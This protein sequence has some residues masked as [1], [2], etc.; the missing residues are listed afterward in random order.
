VSIKQA[1]DPAPAATFNT[2]D[3][4][5][6]PFQAQK[7]V[8]L[9][10]SQLAQTLLENVYDVWKSSLTKKLDELIRQNSLMSPNK[11]PA[12]RFRG[13]LLPHS[14]HPCKDQEFLPTS[15]IS[16]SLKPAFLQ[17]HDEAEEIR[18]EKVKVSN[19]FASIF[20]C[21][22]SMDSWR[23]CLHHSLHAAF[24]NAVSSAPSTMTWG[25]DSPKLLNSVKATQAPYQALVGQRNFMVL[26][27]CP[28]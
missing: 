8:M 4:M 10:K 23:E 1:G 2:G 9:F 26:I 14:N 21:L 19:S 24:D 17:W 3:T 28:S 16:F 25:Y 6:S 7:E 5:V 15:P 18:L 13:Q 12:V 27:Y 22:K 11:Q 20:S